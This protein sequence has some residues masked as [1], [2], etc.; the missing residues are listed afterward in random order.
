MGNAIELVF[1]RKRRWVALVAVASLLLMILAAIRLTGGRAVNRTFQPVVTTE[2]NVVF[3]VPMAHSIG[4]WGRQPRLGLAQSTGL[5]PY[6]I[7]SNEVLTAKREVRYEATN[8]LLRV[9][10][11][12]KAA[13]EWK[14]QLVLSNKAQAFDRNPGGRH[15][16]IVVGNRKE[17][18]TS[19][20]FGGKAEIPNQTS[21]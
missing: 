7:V 16:S 3:E 13:T 19:D 20:S 2:S 15:H 18:W 5:N 11:P 10:V 21:E 8:K 6:Y 1:R 14:F 12:R 9:T 4:F 17:V